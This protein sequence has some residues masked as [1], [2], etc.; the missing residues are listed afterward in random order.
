MKKRSITTND[1]NLVCQYQNLPTTGTVIFITVA[2]FI[3]GVIMG[4]TSS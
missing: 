4:V 1:P 3:T 2:A